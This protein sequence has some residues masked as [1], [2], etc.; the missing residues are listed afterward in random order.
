MFRIGIKSIVA[1]TFVVVVVVGCANQAIQDLP[2]YTGVTVDRMLAEIGETF[3]DPAF[4]YRDGDDEYIA[5]R[6]PDVRGGFFCHVVYTSRGGSIV[7]VDMVG[8]G[9]VTVGTTMGRPTVN[10]RAERLENERMGDLLKS[11]GI[12]LVWELDEDGTGELFYF[13]GADAHNT[14]TAPTGGNVGV[15]IGIVTKCEATVTMV[16]GTVEGVETKGGQCWAT[17]F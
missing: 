13:F 2:D 3:G 9:C 11:F 12:P 16:H 1:A 14:G 8:L 10:A 15:S 5:F 6:A 7:A 17:R 4:Q